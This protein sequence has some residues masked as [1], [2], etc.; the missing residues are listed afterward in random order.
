MK[1]ATCRRVYLRLTVQTAHICP[2]GEHGRGW[3]DMVL[4]QELKGLPNVEILYSH[5]VEEIL[6][7]DTVEAV[8]LKDCRTE[9][10]FRLPVDGVFV[11]GGIRPQTELV[12]GLAACDDGGY[13]LA[14]EDCATN[15]PGLYAAGDVRKKPVR[16]IITA[17]ADGANAAVAAGAFCSR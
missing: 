9:E 13:V 7:E 1:K 6:G 16:Q 3:A 10:T 8:T 11:A 2:D 15:I 17:V 14:G 12:R 5:V 4:Q